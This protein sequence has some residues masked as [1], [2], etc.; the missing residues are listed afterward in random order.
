MTQE[1]K[2][3]L[4]RK[5]ALELYPFGDVGNGDARKGYIA[6]ATKYAEKV[7]EKNVEIETL[8]KIQDQL[9][10]KIRQLEETVEFG[11]SI[12]TPH[13][14]NKARINDL[15]TQ[16]ESKDQELSRQKDEY[17]VLQTER[18]Q[19]YDVFISTQAELSRLKVIAERLYK[20]FK[21]AI[22]YF[23]KVLTSYAE[24]S[25]QNLK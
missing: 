19:W 22:D 24:W 18:N 9:L 3:E 15:K 17:R 4:I 6:G 14:H 20:D 1:T 7:E 25:K 23:D 8:Q 13:Q 5:E 21:E 12:G 16:L 11:F 10:S 2:D